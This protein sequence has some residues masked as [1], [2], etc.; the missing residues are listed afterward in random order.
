MKL[1][2]L[3]IIISL[4]GQS[5]EEGEVIRGKNYK[6]VI[7][8]DNFHTLLGFREQPYEGHFT[9][10]IEIIGQLESKLRSEIESLNVEGINQGKGLGPVIHKN[11]KKYYRQYIGDTNEDGSK[12]ILINFIWTKSKVLKNAENDWITVYD[13]GSFYWTIKYNLINNKFYDLQ[14]NGVA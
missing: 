8:P 12:Y 14:V 9:P 2:L 5:I 6:G 4:I 11:L 13:G 1:L 7:F 3:N 10:S